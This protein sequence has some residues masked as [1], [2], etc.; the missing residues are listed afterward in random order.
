MVNR[1]TG[2]KFH[3][4]YFGPPTKRHMTQRMRNPKIA[5]VRSVQPNW[6]SYDIT[7]IRET[8][9]RSTWNFRTIFGQRKCVPRW[10][11]V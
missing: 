10:N 4:S 7:N 2:K 8:T 11:I 1:K 6:P 3:T 9:N 5:V